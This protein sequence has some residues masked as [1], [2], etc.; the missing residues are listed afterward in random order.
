MISEF[1]QVMQGAESCYGVKVSQVGYYARYI[2]ERWSIKCNLF[3]TSFGSCA[4]FYA[5]WLISTFDLVK[6]SCY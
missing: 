2:H 3:Y 6:I 5:L 1:L 4:L